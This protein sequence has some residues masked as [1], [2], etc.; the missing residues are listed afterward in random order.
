VLFNLIKQRG[1]QFVEGFGFKQFVIRPD[2]GKPTQVLPLLIKIILQ[3]FGATNGIFNHGIRILWGDGINKKSIAEICSIFIEHDLSTVNVA[4]GMGGK[5]LQGVN[6]DT[7]SF[8]MKASAIGVSDNPETK[9]Y[10][11]DK[12]LEFSKDPIDDSGKTSLAGLQTTKIQN[13]GDGTITCSSHKY[14][15][16]TE[17]QS[18]VCNV[19]SSMTVVYCNGQLLKN[20]TFQE[21]RDRLNKNTKG[22]NALMC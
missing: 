12:W 22:F 21:V 15:S 7:A 4:F 20:E 14:E 2:S 19:Y 10:T 1:E 16:Y 13:N 8:A 6:R 5:L 3:R 11:C 9:L 18:N 17:L